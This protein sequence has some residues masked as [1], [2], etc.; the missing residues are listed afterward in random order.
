MAYPGM[1]KVF[2]FYVPPITS[3]MGKATDFKVGRYI[4]YVHPNK[5]D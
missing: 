5:D 4:H 1:P 3:G 2:F